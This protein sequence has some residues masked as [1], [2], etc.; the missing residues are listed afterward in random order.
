MDNTMPFAFLR[1]GAQLPAIPLLEQ[2]VYNPH[3]TL[4]LVD[5]VHNT[6]HVATL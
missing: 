2:D 4:I 6:M 3:A 5:V 1:A